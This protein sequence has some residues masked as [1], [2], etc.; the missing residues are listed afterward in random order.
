[1]LAEE[2][3]ELG[4]KEYRFSERNFQY[5]RRLVGAQTG[6]VLSDAKRDMVYARLVRRLRTLKLED[7]SQYCEYLEANSETELGAM[8]NAITT[9]LTSFFREKHHFEFLRNKVLPELMIRKAASR[10]LRIWSAGCSTGEE[11]YSIATVLRETLDS[12]PDWDCRILASDLD[13]DVLARAERGVYPLDRV[14]GIGEAILKRWF[15]RGKG[16]NSGQ[17]RVVRE[18]RDMITFRRINLVEDWPVKGP[19]DVVFC[20]NVVIYF[21]KET[22][23]K[24][25][26]RFADVMADHSYLFIGHSE[27]LFKVTGRFEMTGSTTYRK[28]Y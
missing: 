28:K 26:E 3:R 6:I 13:T 10:R 23:R 16:G 21:D 17:A 25:F 24:I 20:R 27:T 4:E 18:L 12:N 8:I 22:Q 9:N 1:M 2:I 5:I 19:I 14:A 7:F 15:L 11:P